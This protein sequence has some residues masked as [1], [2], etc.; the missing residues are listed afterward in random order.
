MKKIIAFVFL[1]PIQNSFADSEQTNGVPSFLAIGPGSNCHVDTSS[2]FMLKDVILTT[3]VTELRVTNDVIH[4]GPFNPSKGYYIR[5]G[6]TNCADA[7]N[8]I[9]GTIPSVLDGDSIDSTMTLAVNDNYV[10][11]NIKIINGSASE[12]GGLNLTAIDMT[13]LLDRVIVENNQA[14][15]GAGIYKSGIN[16]NVNLTVVD[17]VINSNTTFAGGMGGGIYFEGF[18]DVV[19]YGDTLIS[20]NEA[21]NGGGLYFKDANATIV[22]GPNP[23]FDSGIRSNKARVNGGGIYTNA[24]IL[25][26]TGGTKDIQS[27]GTV[28][29]SGRNYLLLGNTA[30]SDNNSSGNGG[31]IFADFFSQLTLNAISIINNQAF[32]AGGGIMLKQSSHLEI[33]FPFNSNCQTTTLMG[34][35]FIINNQ[36]DQGGGLYL[37]SNSVANINSVNFNGNRA[38]KGTIAIAFGT[39]TL[40]I[41]SSVMYNN[42]DSGTNGFDDTYALGLFVDSQLTIEQTTA[43]KN[44]TTDSFIRQFLG[45][46]ALFSYNNYFYNPASGPWVDLFSNSGTTTHDCQVVDDTNNISDS[47]NHL[48]IADA[49]S[50][51]TQ[52]FINEANHDYHLQNTSDLIDFVGANCPSNPNLINN[53]RDIDNQPRSPLAD[54][55]ADENL[56]N[57][58]F[59]F[60]DGFEN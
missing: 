30:D 2:G 23:L 59:I 28:G 34:C 25:E 50:N 10:L 39:S 55:G 3:G 53:G 46:N 4:T 1:L 26:I 49:S 48:T 51:D 9:Q 42:G 21:D 35:N 32:G 17:S 44:K 57:V 52:Y 36:V 5:G 41:T 14:F 45:N 33:G 47:M 58:P 29:L 11:E 13:V 38:N 8:D 24:S 37:D 7:L 6:Y 16:D 20:Q 18:G 12:G 19:I 54:L 40:N 31:G 15:S 43:V 60:S 56:I 22:V 27:I